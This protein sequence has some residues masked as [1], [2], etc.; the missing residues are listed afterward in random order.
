MATSL[1]ARSL[2][3]ESWLPNLVGYAPVSPVVL[4]NIDLDHAEMGTHLSRFTEQDFRKARKVYEEGAN[5]KPYAILT[6]QRGLESELK[7]GWYVAGQT[8]NGDTITG[9]LLGNYPVGASQIAVIYGAEV[10]DCSV[11]ASYYPIVEGCFKSAGSIFVHEMQDAPIP[12]TYDPLEDNQSRM[13]LQKLSTHAKEKMFA[14]DDHC[15]FWLYSS[16]VEY[17]GNFSYADHWIQAAFEGGTTNLDEANGDFRHY[18]Y[19]ARAEII[20]KASVYMSLWMTVQN[21][22]DTAIMQCNDDCRNK[23]CNMGSLHP[24]DLAVA[25]YAGSLEGPD[26]NGSGNGRLLHNLADKRCISF[27]TC[28]GYNGLSNVNDEV[29]EL[30]WEGQE[31]IVQGDCS[32]AKN[33]QRRISSLL[34]VPLIQETLWYAHITYSKP[35]ELFSQDNDAAE[36]ISAG[37]AT[38]AAA[39][40]PLIHNCD[41][42]AGLVVYQNL[43]TGHDANFGQVKRALE[44][45]YECLEILCED[46]GGLYYS[47]S[48]VPGAE[49][50]NFD[51]TSNK[52]KH[53]R[54]GPT[55]LGIVLIVLGIVALFGICYWL[56]GYRI[57]QEE[58]VK[59]DVS[60][61]DESENDSAAVASNNQNEEGED[62]LKIE[63][64]DF[65]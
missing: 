5:A 1:N 10:Y 58:G 64:G 14:C 33:I 4:D 21:E 31:R 38:V 45:T 8:A 26:A 53:H 65:A 56:S 43:K 12:Y 16:F 36:K 46:V 2:A 19:P 41:P 48:Y 30:F 50:C 35:D 29:L 51:F 24:W 54:H 39:I 52:E 55:G 28:D 7:S 34:V 59:E 62:D 32:E 57:S 49:P 44:S 9:S 17:Y 20:Q 47:S 63:K 3:S 60:V 11:G 61:E 25:F 42:E 13:S 27:N 40:L 23:D 18:G 37:A 6:L 15:P 22:L